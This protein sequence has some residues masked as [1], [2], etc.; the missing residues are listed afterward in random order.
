MKVVNIKK[1]K[2]QL[3]G[4]PLFTGKAFSQTPVPDKEGI[5]ISVNFIHFTKGIRNK[6]H[7][8]SNDQVL[9]V[10]EG[11]GIVA[12]RDKKV[13][14]KKGDVIWTPAGEEHWHGA[15]PGSTFSH[16]S[17]TKAHT[18]LTQIEE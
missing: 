18:K 5:N 15:E 3:L 6:F 17:V 2:K 12:T 14:V 16:I 10:T 7:K 1:I 4:A 13:K 9:I 11:T 8:H